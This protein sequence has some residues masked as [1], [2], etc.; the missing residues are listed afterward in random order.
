M[1]RAWPAAALA[2]LLLLAGCGGELQT[3]GEALRIFAS[4]LPRAYLGESYQAQVRAVGGLRPF[5]FEV[6]E[7]S[8]PPGLA[9][10]A[11]AIR[12]VPGET[13]SFD[14]TIVVSDANL[15]RT[16]E[17]YTLQVVERPP[18]ALLLVAPQTEIREAVTVR[19]RI[20]NAS[21]LRAVSA[22]IEWDTQ[23]F[24]LVE[25]SAEAEVARS[26][27]FWDVAE[28]SLQADLAALGEAWEGE[29]SLLR[30]DLMPTEAAVLQPTLTGRFIDD[31]GGSRVQGA[32]EADA[33][34]PTGEEEGAQ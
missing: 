15:S 31:R 6:E 34:G 1:R 30:F 4:D 32:A 26:A 27:L 29:L 5:T 9:L 33:P 2:S 23:R 17:D 18:P 8:L 16:F 3:P 21:Q 10:E 14:F 28:G 24:S 22:R 7:G 20:E 13:G 19:L 12:G 25:G 11:G